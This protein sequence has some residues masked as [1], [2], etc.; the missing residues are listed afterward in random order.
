MTVKSILIQNKLI[1]RENSV[2]KV[3][4]CGLDVQISIPGSV[5]QFSLLLHVQNETVPYIMGTWI[6]LSANDH[7]LLSSAK[8]I[9]AWSYTSTY[10][11]VFIAWC[12]LMETS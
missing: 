10:P 1:T 8:V 5:G 7:S 4:G 11:H 12:L 9:S 2:S 6:L 3:T